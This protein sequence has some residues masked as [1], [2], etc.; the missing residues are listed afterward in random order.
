MIYLSIERGSWTQN[1][2]TSDG[3]EIS[4]CKTGICDPL[5]VE[6]PLFA[7]TSLAH[8]FNNNINLKAVPFWF[9]KGRLLVPG[10]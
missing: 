4:D 7:S 8:V 6:S 10:L 2:S 3:H 9:L 5:V 1:Q